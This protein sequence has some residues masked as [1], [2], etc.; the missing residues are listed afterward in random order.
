MKVMLTLIVT[1]MIYACA[2]SPPSNNG[3]PATDTA[4]QAAPQN[5]PEASSTP[6]KPA[7]SPH[8]YV[9]DRDHDLG[10]FGGFV[11]DCT[12]EQNWPHFWKCQS[13]NSGNGGFN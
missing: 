7:K 3:Q 5:E 13:E 1:L 12:D 6:A 11:G 10:R 4:N 9:I 2:A 8:G